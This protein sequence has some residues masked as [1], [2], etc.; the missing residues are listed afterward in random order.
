MS[1]ASFILPNFNLDAL[2]G[3]LIAVS[4]GLVTWLSWLIR[5]WKD[6]KTLIKNI[7]V[8]MILGGFAYWFIISWFQD[9]LADTKIWMTVVAIIILVVIGIMIFWKK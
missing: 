7:G 8:T 9:M 2:V 3:I 1:L 5:G 6:F 4:G